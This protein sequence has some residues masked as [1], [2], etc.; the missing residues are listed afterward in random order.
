MRIKTYFTGAEL[1]IPKSKILGGNVFEKKC[2]TRVK[3]RPD[4]FSNKFNNGWCV[5]KFWSQS[6]LFTQLIC[7]NSIKLSMP[8]YRYCFLVV[9]I[10]RMI[11]TFS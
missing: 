1:R 5:L 7:N 11:G 8:F 9:S 10:D 2:D 6:C 4:L 3:R